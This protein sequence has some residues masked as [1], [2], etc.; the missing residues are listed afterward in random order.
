MLVMIKAILYEGAV[1][2][3]A[4]MNF[5]KDFRGS[6]P[7]GDSRRSRWGE[8]TVETGGRINDMAEKTIG[9]IFS[10]WGQ[11]TR[12]EV[13]SWSNYQ[14]ANVHLGC[15]GQLGTFRDA[16]Q[17]FGWN[18]GGVDAP[19]ASHNYGPDLF[20]VSAAANSVKTRAS[21]IPECA[22]RVV[23]RVVTLFAAEC[24]AI[25]AGDRQVR[26]SVYCV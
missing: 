24:A 11:G 5:G 22:D 25:D 23:P 1:A 4:S 21:T 26:F 19:K 18:F 12:V 3:R 20:I 15:S 17:V 16:C 6:K 8:K 14:N 7:W 10:T 9:E 13:I 2:L